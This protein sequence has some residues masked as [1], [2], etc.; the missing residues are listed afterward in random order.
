[1]ARCVFDNPDTM[2]REWWED[3]EMMYH[4]A[5]ILLVTA[6]GRQYFA[7]E[8]RPWEAGHVVGDLWAREPK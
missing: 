1:V 4:V 5:A 7:E 3:G 2:C 8:P 6:D